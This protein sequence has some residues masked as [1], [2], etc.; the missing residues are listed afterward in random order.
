MPP[1]QRKRLNPVPRFEAD[2]L[3]RLAP[4]PDPP[5]RLILR[6]RVLPLSQQR[7]LERRVLGTK[8]LALSPSARR[9]VRK[10]RVLPRCARTAAAHAAPGLAAA[11]LLARGRSLE[12][13]A[14]RMWMTQRTLVALSALPPRARPASLRLRPVSNNTTDVH[15]RHGGVLGPQAVALA[16]RYLGTPYLWGGTDPDRRVRLLRADDVGL[17]PV[18]H[19]ARPSRGRQF[20]EGDRVTTEQLQPGDLVSSTRSPTARA[21]SGST[22]ATAR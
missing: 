3:P 20:P 16:K 6:A 22:W 8:H 1:P 13:Q 12:V 17:P 15:A 4:E 18:R 21:T 9:D 14:T 7:A 11:R 19:L 5:P 10:H 2:H